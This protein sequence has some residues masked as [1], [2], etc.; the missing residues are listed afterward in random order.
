MCSSHCIQVLVGMLRRLGVHF[1]LPRSQF[2][3]FDN[4]IDLSCGKWI[5]LTN[6]SPHCKLIYMLHKAKT[7]DFLF[8]IAVRITFEGPHRS[9]FSAKSD[10]TFSWKF[11][12]L[13]GK[14][15]TTNKKVMAKIWYPSPKKE[16]TR[17][18]RFLNFFY[19]KHLL[20]LA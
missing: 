4:Q 12:K 5:C 13:K 6:F 11:S 8:L 17:L 9:F 15:R 18:Y 3:T 1:S 19:E 14:N 10:S 2:R 16:V 20:F 7:K